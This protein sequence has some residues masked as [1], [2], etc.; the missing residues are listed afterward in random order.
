M[1][2]SFWKKSIFFIFGEAAK[3]GWVGGAQRPVWL[4]NAPKKTQRAQI[5]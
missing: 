2:Q 3:L 4:G 5:H 1:L